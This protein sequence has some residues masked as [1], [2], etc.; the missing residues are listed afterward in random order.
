[1]ETIKDKIKQQYKYGGMHMKLLMIN[2]GVFLVFAIL[3][4]I[5]KLFLVN[6]GYFEHYFSFFSNPKLFIRQPWGIITYMFMHGSFMHILMNMLIFFF[7]G[8]MLEEFMGSKKLLSTYIIGGISAAVLFFITQNFLPLYQHQFTV[9]LIGAS[10]AVMAILAA[11]AT[12]APN[13]EV[14]LFGIIRMPLYLIAIIMAAIDILSVA[15]ADGVAHFAHIGGLLYG[16]VF[17]SQWK[18]GKDISKWFDRF[19]AFLTGIFKR[20]PKMKVEYSKYRKSNKSVKGKR[21]K[22]D[23]YTYN[24]Q[25]V[26]RQAKLDRILDKIKVS[27]YEGLTKE[28]KDFLANF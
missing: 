13:M 12:Y 28:E 6:I 19:I 24:E 4:L 8:R 18:K 1:M 22:G 15:N 5:G 10:G 9:E 20:Q 7:M 3:A 11:T 25:K 21:S 16:Y 23:K 26:D 14:F 27:G 17:A 2:V